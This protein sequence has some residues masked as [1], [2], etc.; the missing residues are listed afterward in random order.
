MKISRIGTLLGAVLV[1]AFATLAQVPQQW[2]IVTTSE[3]AANATPIL[4]TAAGVYSPCTTGQND[5][6]KD[7]NASCFN[8][9]TITTDWNLTGLSSNMTITPV[10][11]DTFTNS[12][13]SAMGGVNT[14]T[15]TGYSLVTSY[16]TTVTVTV[17]D[18]NGAT[19]TIVFTGKKSSNSA[20]FTGTFSSSGPCM[21]SDKG[22]FT[23][24][25]FSTI[26]GTYSGSF[27]T[28]GFFNEN[29]SG[30]V[31]LV[32][33]TGSNFNITGTAVA[34]AS[35]GLCFS[36]LTIA[37]TL[38]N[39]YMTSM[40]TGD[41]LAFV[42]T[43]ASGNVVLFTASGTSGTGQQEGDNTQGNQL[44][45][46]TY[47]GLAGTCSGKSGVDIPFSEVTVPSAP[48]HGVVFGGGWGGPGGLGH[49]GHI[50]PPTR[51]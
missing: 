5:N 40:A 18:G 13:C 29:G 6:S 46:V 2:T 42:A 12:S 8:P 20:Q 35:S 41:T 24:T 34:L 21:K 50:I 16:T 17:I 7:K 31:T 3:S 1:A 30:G 19:N 11:A 25:L 48:S 15:A 28:N 44:L 36:N 51:W 14:I 37:T 26:T 10:A 33:T 43:D 49:M 47:T 4:Y 9:L 23:A 22:N 39:T 32:I 38:A 27:E 45:Y